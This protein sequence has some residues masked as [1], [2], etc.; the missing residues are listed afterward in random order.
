MTA[1]FP[2]AS[3]KGFHFTQAI[4]RQVQSLG[5]A[6]QYRTDAAVKSSVRHLMALGFAPL[7]LI[8][9]VL[10]QLEAQAPAILQ[11]LF[12]YFRTQWLTSVPPPMWN[13]HN[14]EQRERTNNHLEGWHNG[15]NRLLNQHHPNMWRLLAALQQEQAVT[16][17]TIQQIAAG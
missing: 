17:V 9:T 7:P 5:L 12:T 4:W 16:D 15:F 6:G 1:S 8:R 11:T 13:V 3:H 14:M 2:N 10:M